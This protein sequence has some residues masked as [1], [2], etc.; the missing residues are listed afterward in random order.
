MLRHENASAKSLWGKAHSST[1]FSP[2]TWLLILDIYL[3]AK[4]IFSNIL[5]FAQAA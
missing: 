4:S 3:D 2:T 1:C 5:K